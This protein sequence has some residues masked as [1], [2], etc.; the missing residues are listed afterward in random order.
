MS[1][2]ARKY[3]NIESLSSGDI[4]AILDSIKSYNQEDNENTMNDSDT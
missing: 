3:V 2:S 4:F 1:S